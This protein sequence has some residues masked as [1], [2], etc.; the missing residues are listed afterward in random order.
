MFEPCIMATGPLGQPLTF[1]RDKFFLNRMLNRIL[2]ASKLCGRHLSLEPD[3]KP[4]S[5]LSAGNFLT[6]FKLELARS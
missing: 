5:S 1:A 3:F 2:R 4:E 6:T